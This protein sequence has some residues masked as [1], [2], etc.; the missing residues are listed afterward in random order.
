M[1]NNSIACIFS[2]SGLTLSDE[3]KQLFEKAKPFGFI[4]FARNC[5]TPDQLRA[6]NKSLRET[7][8]WH[9]P[10]LIDQEGGRVQRL[11]PPEWQQ[12]KPMQYYGDLWN[13]EGPP[14]AK[15]I[16]QKDTSVLAKELIDVSVNVN[17][18]PV[19]DV[20]TPETHD[21]IGDRAFSDDPD[22][23]AALGH[24]V[25]EE[26]LENS[27]TPI[28]KHL[29]GH[30]RATADSHLELPSVDASLDDLKTTDFLPFEKLAKSNIANQIWG[31]PT[32][33]L[34]PALDPKHAAC[35]SSI[36]IHDI[37]RAEM[38]FKNILVSDAVDMKGFDAYG[39]AAER[40]NSVLAAG[41]DLAT[42]CT[43]KLDEM[44]NIAE[45]CP[46]LRDDTLERLQAWGNNSIMG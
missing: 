42:H 11:K 7:V 25:C 39:N 10:I 23:V 3:E 17:C 4:L 35:A 13:T 28:I 21:V 19:L 9:C 27:I 40:V 20:L 16:L 2:A 32:P 46:K 36:I 29:P 22:V 8:G 31:M 6:L 1:N 15:R 43:G 38:G 41:C 44:Q 45:T 37:I 24:V 33:V 30:G 5:E 12:H 18:A 14:E 26:F 34:Y